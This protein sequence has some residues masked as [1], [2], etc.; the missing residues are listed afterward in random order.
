MAIIGMMPC[1]R[2]DL[3]TYYAMLASAAAAAV[4]A[5]SVMFT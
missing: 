2:N 5:R 1:F 3:I 4:A